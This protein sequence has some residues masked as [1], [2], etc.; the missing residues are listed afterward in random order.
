M[1]PEPRTEPFYS[2]ARIDNQG[3][4]H[5]HIVS[6]VHSVDSLLAAGNSCASALSP[7]LAVTFAI[8]HCG[9]SRERCSRPDLGGG[10]VAGS[11]DQRA[12]S[13]LIS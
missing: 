5:V 9:D 2:P 7:G 8:S 6:V 1:N 13:R 11:V 4:C 10:D 12:V 3:G